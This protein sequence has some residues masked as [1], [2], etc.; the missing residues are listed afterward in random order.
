MGSGPGTFAIPYQNTKSPESEMAR[1]CH[2]D[3]LEQATDSGL[4][5]GISYLLFI[6][7]NIILIWSRQKHFTSIQLSLALG[8]TAFALQGVSEFSLYIP[9]IA[10]PFFI[11]LG[12]MSHSCAANYR[13]KEKKI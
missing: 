6:S 1:L 4:P 5:A 12:F 10:W 11:L 3:Y 8:V 13:L 7:G 9:A 2:N